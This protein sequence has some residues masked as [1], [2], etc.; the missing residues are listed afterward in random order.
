[1]TLHFMRFVDRVCGIPLC[2]IAGA[3]L[4]LVRRTRVRH[5]APVTAIRK[6]LVIKFFGLG[7]ILL[8][9]PALRTLK[10]SLPQAQI[11]F[12][13]FA[14]HKEM[15]ERLPSVDDVLVVRTSSLRGFL[16]DLLKL[17]C[18][19]RQRRFDVVFDFEFFSKFSTFLS[20]LTQ[21]PYRIGFA[22]PT[23]WR[24]AILTHPVLLEKRQHVSLSFGKQIEALFGCEPETHIDPPLIT[25][26][27]DV[28][29]RKEIGP[30]PSLFV[31]M[32]VN[33]G[34][35]FLER[36]WPPDRFALLASELIIKYSMP[37]YFIGLKHERSY[38]EDVLR[39]IPFREECHNL[40][41]I[42]SFPLL[43]ALLARCTLFISNDTGPLHLA[44]ALGTPSLGLY[45]PESPQFYGARGP[46]VRLVY[47]KS[48][49]SPCMN[50]Y[51]AKTN[52][53]SYNAECMREIEVNH[54]LQEV[55]QILAEELEVV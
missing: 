51:N 41:G 11:T 4:A 18:H 31:V 3:S 22:L 39:L 15:L 26:R 2:W 6:I 8:I 36:R 53:C 45:G 21:A 25:P 34:E 17:L 5:R 1:M 43:A 55:D 40:A 27:D 35:T 32:N 7:S 49:C 29:L 42:L 33:A 47:G 16:S 30:L 52:H 20:A 14:A 28:T 19:L 24:T 46:R 37:I 13:S 54:V 23:R 44:A 12:L 50:V 48:T 10:Q 9:T 38:V